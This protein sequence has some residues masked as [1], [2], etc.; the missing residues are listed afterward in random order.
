VTKSDKDERRKQQDPAVQRGRPGGA[1]H[2]RTASV[3]HGSCEIVASRLDGSSIWCL[4]DLFKVSHSPPLGSQ[5]A[6]DNVRSRAT[7]FAEKI[8]PPFLER[9]CYS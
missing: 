5:F 4:R 1:N 6:Y 9:E 8:L 7:G 3:G 2:A